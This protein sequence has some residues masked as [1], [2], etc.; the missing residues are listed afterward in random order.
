M[1]ISHAQLHNKQ[2]PQSVTVTVTVT[3]TVIV[4]VIVTVTATVT[5][6]CYPDHFYYLYYLRCSDSSG[7]TSDSFYSYC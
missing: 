6:F 5:V 2:I 3:V 7:C 1:I 4:T